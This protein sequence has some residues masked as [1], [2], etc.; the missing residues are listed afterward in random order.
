M[1]YIGLCIVG[2]GVIL[3]SYF[4]TR[5]YERDYVESLDS[6]E[7]PFKQLYPLFLYLLLETSCGIFLERGKKEKEQLQALHIGENIEERQILFW[8][9]KLALLLLVCVGCLFFTLC[10]YG[11]N[12]SE[13]EAIPQTVLTREQAGNGTKTVSLDVSLSELWKER[14]EVVVPEQVYTQEE[15]A[16][17]MKEAK[18]Y[19]QTYYLGEN[20]SEQQVEYPLYFMENIPGSAISVSWN[21]WNELLVNKDG[22]LENAEI[23]TEGE[24]C[25]LT[26]NL[27]YGEYSEQLQFQI[28]VLPKRQ[29]TKEDWKKALQ[30]AILQAAKENPTQDQM[31]LPAMVWDEPVSYWKP[32]K[33]TKPV[34]LMFGIF[35][36][37]ALWIGFQKDLQSKKNKRDQ[38]MLVDYPELVNKFILLLSAGMTISGAWGK[39]AMEYEKKRK[40]DEK[41]KRYAYEEWLF[42]WTELENGVTQV[43]AL[44]HFGQRIGLMPYLKFSTMLATNAKKG[45]KGLLELLEYEALDLFEHRKQMTRR[46]AEEAGTKLLAPMMIMLVLV[47]VI[48]MA[49]AFLSL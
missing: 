4:R 45:S 42:T 18:E 49:P 31:E 25:Q 35:L 23:S 15:L 36:M 30:E 34:V 33:K 26:A 14:I 22:T 32:T 11:A 9:K 20:V 3:V 28:C 16:V 37:G 46:I 2:L 29:R 43:K 38:Q 21:I 13:T 44:E 7:H 39:I 41:K 8:C 12:I 19:V 1:V 5:Q 10:S 6:K 40:L 48:I 24:I 17:K 47:M 27:I